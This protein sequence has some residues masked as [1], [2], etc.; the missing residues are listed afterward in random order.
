MMTI[1]LEVVLRLVKKKATLIDNY[2]TSVILNFLL[3]YKFDEEVRVLLYL[4]A[5]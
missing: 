2:R 5:S 1:F 4:E 3:S